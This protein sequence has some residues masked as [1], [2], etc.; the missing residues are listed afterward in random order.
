MSEKSSSSHDSPAAQDPA[1]TAS[2][3]ADPQQKEE[4]ARGEVDIQQL[5]DNITAKAEL[6]TPTETTTS[7]TSA[8]QAFST[9]PTG[10]PA[11]SSLPPRPHSVQNGL[12]FPSFSAHDAARTTYAGASSLPPPPGIGSFRAPGVP[13]PAAPGAPGTGPTSLL[14]PP[15]SSMFAPPPG[16]TVPPMPIHF[17]PSRPNTAGS[18]QQAPKK[19]RSDGV[20]HGEIQWSAKVQKHYEEFLEDERGYVQEG[21]WDKFPNGSRLFIGK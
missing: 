2:P 8:P 21:Q 16:V 12:P 10:L 7:S 4:V 14:P 17:Q 13:G 19:D 15:P 5:L 3:Q 1:K 11:H 9:I 18:G 20:D 6:K